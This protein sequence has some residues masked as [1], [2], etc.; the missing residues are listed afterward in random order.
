MKVH[1]Y[2]HMAARLIVSLVAVLSFVPM[3]AQDNQQY[4]L[5]NYRN[6]GA[7]NA[8]LNID[9]DSITYSRIDTL[10]VEHDDIVVQE[11]WTPDS[12]YRIPLDA[13]DSL[14]F[15]VPEPEFREGLFYLRDYHAYNTYAKDSLTIYFSPVILRD[16]LPAVGQ[17]IVSMTDLSPYEHGFAGKVVGVTYNEDHIKVECTNAQIN[18]I[19]KHFIFV[20]K[21]VGNE[22]PASVPSEMKKAK[23]L[24]Y[25]SGVKTYEL[26]DINLSILNDILSVNSVKPKVTCYCIAYVDE[27]FYQISADAFIRHDDISYTI[28]VNDDIIRRLDTETYG[29]LYELMTNEPFDKETAEEMED[30]LLEAEWKQKISLLDIP[31]GPVRLRLDFVPSFKMSGNV[32]ASYQYS[33]KVKQHIGF[34][35]KNITM[36]S[37]AALYL[38]GVAPFLMAADAFKNTTHTFEE[39]KS[40]VNHKIGL[41]LN[42]SLSVGAAL[43]LCVCLW[44]D[45]VAHASVGGEAGLKLKGTI[46]FNLDTKDFDDEEEDMYNY[47]LWYGLTKDTKAEAELYAK[48]TGEIGITP[49]KFLTLEGSIEPESWKKELGTLYLF[50]HFTKPALPQSYEQG[51]WEYS[52]LTMKSI[53]SNNLLFSSNLGM[54][55]TDDMKDNWLFYTPA[56]E[57]Y[58]NEEEWKKA[59]DCLSIS[60]SNLSPGTYYCYPAFRLWGN[61]L[62]KAGPYTK[63]EVPEQLSI[64]T[65][66]VNI[67]IGERKIIYYTGGWE[68]I[69][70]RVDDDDRSVA[71]VTDGDGYIVITGK[72]KGTAHITVEDK[73]SHY[74]VVLTVTVSDNFSLTLSASTL[75]LTPG[76]QGTVDVTSGSGSY[77]A[78]SNAKDVATVTVEGSKI[79]IKAVAPGSATITVKDNQTQERAKIEVTVSNTNTPAGLQAVDLGLPSGTLWANMNV[80]ATAPEEYGGYYAWGET[81]EKSIYK[82]VTYQYASGVDNDGDGY[83]DDWHGSSYGEWQNIGNDIAGTVYDVAHVKWGGDWNMPSS[84]QI[85]ELIDYT[86]SEWTYVNGVY[87]RMFTSIV[88]GNSNSIFLPASG[89]RI[90]DE[91]RDTGSSGRYWSSKDYRSFPRSAY[92]LDFVYNNVRKYDHY[93]CNGMSVRPVISPEVSLEAIDLGLPSGTKWAN[94]NLG[95][96]KPEGIGNL[97]AWGETVSKNN[98]SWNNYSLCDG[99]EESCYNI[100][101]D[102]SLTK[103]DAAHVILK[104]NWRMPS[105]EEIQELVDNCDNELTVENGVH[106][107][108]F[109]NKKNDENS[110]FIPFIDYIE[111][112]GFDAKGRL[113]TST[114]DSLDNSK[115]YTLNLDY[116]EWNTAAFILSPSDYLYVMSEK[117]DSGLCVR[118]VYSSY[119]I[120]PTTIDF[121]TVPIDSIKEEKILIKNVSDEI[122]T[123]QITINQLYSYETDNINYFKLNDDSL[124]AL[125]PGE[126][127]SLSILCYGLPYKKSRSCKITIKTKSQTSTV[128]LQG[129]GGDKWYGAN[130]YTVLDNNCLTFY[131]DDNRDY[132]E[133]QGMWTHDLII[134]VSKKEFYERENNYVYYGSCDKIIFDP[135]FANANPTTTYE[136]F[137]H[138][139]I[140]EIVGLQYLNTSNVTDMRR[141]FA[142]CSATNL[143][144]KGLNTSKV[145]DMSEMFYGCSSL[146]SLDLSGFNTSNVTDMNNMFYKCYSLASLDLSNFNTSNVTNMH[147]MFY[148]NPYA[149]RH[150]SLVRLDLSSFNTSNVTDMGEMFKGADALLSLDLSKF[151]TSNVTDMNNMFEDCSSLTS[152]DISHFYTSNVTKMIRMFDS[153]SSLTY[154]D[155]SNFNT[156]NVTDMRSLFSGC[157]SLTSLN[158][159]HFDT[160]KVT[161]MELM[162]SGCSSLTSLDVS[163]FSTS[164]VTNMYAMFSGCSSLTNLDLSSFGTSNVIDMHRMFRRC[165]QLKTVYVGNDWT[166][167]NVETSSDMFIEC[168]NIKGGNGTEYD[169]NHIDKEYARID[170]RPNRPG[171]FSAGMFSFL[172]CP[173]YDHPHLIDLGLPSGTKWACCNVNDDASKQIPTNNGTFYAW[174]EVKGKDYYSEDTNDY[175][176]NGKW[177]YIGGEIAGTQYDVAHYRWGGSW[178]MPSLDQF[179]ELLDNCSSQWM[180]VGGINGLSFT[181]SN[182]CTIFLPA[183]GYVYNDDLSYVG[184]DATYWSST[185]DPSDSDKA[186]ILYFDSRNAVCYGSSREGGRTVRPVTDG[187]SSEIPAEAIDLGLPSGTRWASYNVGA[188]KPEEFGGKYAWGETEVKEDY[189]EENYLYNGQNLGSNICG[190]EYDVAHVKWGG[191]WQMPTKKQIEELINKCTYEVVDIN[192]ISGGKFIGPNGNSVFFPAEYIGWGESFWSGTPS[193]EESDACVLNV[194]RGCGTMYNLYRYRGYCVRPVEVSNMI[195][196]AITVVPE[197]I[198]FGVVKLG[199]DKKRNLTVTNTSN[200]SVTV[201]MDG[202]TK[203]TDCFDVSDNQEAVTLAPGESKVYTITAHGTKAGYRPTQSL[204]VNCD[205]LEEPVE[206]KMSSYGDDDDP[207]VNVTELSLK[208]GETATVVVRNT[209]YYSSIPDV[210]D[211]VEL[212]GGGGPGVSGGPIDRH[213]PFYNYSESELTV[214]ALKAGVVHITFTDHHTNHTSILTV[215]VTGSYTNDSILVFPDGPV[216]MGLPSGT[217]WASH[218]VGATKPEEIGGYYAWGETEV[219]EE[220]EWATYVH[221]DGTAETCRDI[222]S[223]ISGTEYDVA[224]VKWGDSWQMP[225]RADFFELREHCVHQKYTLNGVQGIALTSPNGNSIFMPCPDVDLGYWTSIEWDRTHAYFHGVLYNDNDGMAKCTYNLVRPVKKKD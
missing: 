191:N 216:D 112:R 188:T 26:P 107:W 71:E 150:S 52:P 79:I 152:L 215:T 163:H 146:T 199:T 121:G 15:R 90:N 140:K 132:W 6:D 176:Q 64:S 169:S 7:F 105:K 168:F 102:I 126:G 129:Y 86:I 144:I 41:N 218:N 206:I 186:Y 128:R 224:H 130:A 11:V 75:E 153:C 141:M 201:T 179:K 49:S 192:G 151:D 124:F 43:K 12:L 177:M 173:D 125:M 27:L 58:K 219:K 203:Y 159:S 96:D 28:K 16:S 210:D 42:G 14:T 19:F 98:F 34:E 156:S 50:P 221:C 45:E 25:N 106:G 3:F 161:D 74:S 99:S 134:D 40:A 33:T 193:D 76:S 46:D 72:K 10:G 171:Y 30:K 174:G 181:G 198:H 220:Y 205:G 197:D 67:G 2:Y 127:K 182:G 143:D 77:D 180:T 20:G 154:L 211:I 178:K 13:V 103:Y 131:Y 32:E 22:D 214:K 135:S 60:I 29:L 31:I 59:N 61:K 155:L 39:D 4:A 95:A 117:R 23:G 213:S 73:R 222:G 69:Q 165:S 80:G 36:A 119:K 116:W 47:P 113:W 37:M 120:T 101:D 94:M 145:T 56:E 44:A 164:N 184:L 175:F 70:S 195:P 57:E 87:G 92:Y 97:Y 55:I 89:Y 62:W 5:Y 91:I 100:G 158:V 17:T 1:T 8:W 202:C 9:I 167:N 109:Y 209:G 114:I 223:D 139:P 123:F 63:I 48:V 147:S 68:I 18:D 104:D 172:S 200:A 93:R 189:T 207:I 148:L 149:N 183:A 88:P 208:V 118:P 115:A 187:S 21:V 157:S 51:E 81:E 170:N 142:E 204:L 160:S 190:T 217:L 66:N 212:Q 78:V 194:Q 38:P 225:T 196:P 166:T 53:P 162:F 83:Y 82:P 138:M 185:Q 85:Q 84:K 110:I 24:E 136:W 122:Q 108:R 35:T 137:F 65:Q 111:D 54:V 133:E